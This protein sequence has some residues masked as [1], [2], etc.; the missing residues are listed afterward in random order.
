MKVNESMKEIHGE[1]RLFI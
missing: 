1:E